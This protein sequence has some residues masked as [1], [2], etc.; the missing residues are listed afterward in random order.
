MFCGK[1]ASHY[2]LVLGPPCLHPRCCWWT[3]A[4]Y[5]V[6]QT[7]LLRSCWPY[8]IDIFFPKTIAC[9]P[10]M[11]ATKNLATKVGLDY[12]NIHGCANGC[13]LFRKQYAML[14][15]CPKCGAD[16]FKAYGKSWMVVKTLRHFPLVPWL[17]CI[18]WIPTTFKL[19]R[20]HSKN[21]NANGKVCHVF[22]STLIQRGLILQ[23]NPSI[24]LG[25]ATDGV[26]PF[27]EKN[28]FHSTLPVLILNDN[29]SPWL[30]TNFFFLVTITYNTKAW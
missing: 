10:N 1:H 27:G 7:S 16:R 18:F 15:S 22:D 29:L 23:L 17:F 20:W 14:E 26:N 6:F 24:R 28:N 8:S 3:Y 19:M 13:V 2:T 9:P 11:Y 30:V 5:M 12:K 25:L 4:R 21:R